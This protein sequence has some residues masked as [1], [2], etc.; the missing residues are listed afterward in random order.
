MMKIMESWMTLDEL[1]GANTKCHYKGRDGESLVKNQIP[2]DIWI[3][4]LLLSSGRKS[5]QLA[6][7]S[8]LTG[9]DTGYQFLA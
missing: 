6:P 4:L 2:E 3:A 1:E 8:N 5:H 7:L 9:E